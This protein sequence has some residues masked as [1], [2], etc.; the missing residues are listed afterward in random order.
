MSWHTGLA[1]GALPLLR[2]AWDAPAAVGA[3]CSQRLGGVSEAPWD[4][5]N[6]G[7]AVG[8]AAK[9]VAHNR[10]LFAKALG[11]DP[12]WLNQVH[13][14]HVL[15]L[16]RADLGAQ[17]PTADASWTDEPGLACAVLVADCLPL[18]LATSDGRAV[19]AIHAGWRGLASGVVEATIQAMSD[20][21]GASAA[22]LVAWLGPC[23]GPR[24]FEVGADVLEAFAAGSDSTASLRFVHRPRPDG[25]AKW[26]ADLPGLATDRL[27]RAGVRRISASSLCTVEEASRFFSYRRDGV[28]GRLAAAIWRH[29]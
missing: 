9:A 10:Q 16:G 18:L 5:L 27:R 17:T 19:A 2:P 4:S 11:A 28:T 3:A 21:V 22:D 23:I 24:Q 20:G 25:T 26:L 12:V 1:L 6:L 14:T 13:G 7:G 15:R 8:D 29:G